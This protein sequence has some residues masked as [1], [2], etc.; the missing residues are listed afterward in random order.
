[1]TNVA[2]ATSWNKIS[3]KLRRIFRFI[4]VKMYL[5]LNYDF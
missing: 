3:L 5:I 2:V 1:M 4:S